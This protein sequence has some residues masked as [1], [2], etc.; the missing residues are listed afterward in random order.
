MKKEAKNI[1]G[2]ILRA[3]VSDA[4]YAYIVEQASAAGVTVSEFMRCAACNTS[5]RT[6]ADAAVLRELRRLGGLCKHG[7]T[8]GA[9]STACG[10]AFKALQKYAA[11]LVR[12]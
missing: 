8:S 1:K 4:E 2:R 11:S 10:D 5:V 9:D 3:R 7:I 12:E 6:K